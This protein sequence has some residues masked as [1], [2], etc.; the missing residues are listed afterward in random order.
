MIQSYAN[1][2]SR[3]LSTCSSVL[4]VQNL[5][6][7]CRD[8]NRCTI[9]SNEEKSS[10]ITVSKNTSLKWLVEQVLGSALD[11]TE[12]CSDWSMRP[13]TQSQVE[14]AALDAWCLLP[15]ATRLMEWGFWGEQLID[16]DIVES[17]ADKDSSASYAETQDELTKTWANEWWY[18][19]LVSI[20]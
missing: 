18:S 14:Y 20:S 15:I 6:Q 19:L 7:A 13:L 9:E 3:C 12:Q 1:I 10:E 2:L 17:N 4:D 11:K 5:W 8:S 16:C